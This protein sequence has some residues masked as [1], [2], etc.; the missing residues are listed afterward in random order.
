MNRSENR[1]GVS[2]KNISNYALVIIAFIIVSGLMAYAYISSLKKNER[3][4]DKE[5][6][7][8]KLTAPSGDSTTS[9]G[10]LRYLTAPEK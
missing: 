5:E 6:T 7:I 8:R 4:A 1:M 2:Q 10:V 3:E 9:S